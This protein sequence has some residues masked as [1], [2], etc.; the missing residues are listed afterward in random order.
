M[1][2]II[3]TT[4]TA[5]YLDEKSTAASVFCLL[6]RCMEAVGARRSRRTSGSGE[7]QE[8]YFILRRT[9]MRN[10]DSRAHYFASTVAS[11]TEGTAE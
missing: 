8:A 4:M 1:I 3:T 5:P 6:E 10:G 11:R 7:K 2:I 9:V